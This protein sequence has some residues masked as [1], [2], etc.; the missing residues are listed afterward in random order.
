MTAAVFDARAI[1]IR[2]LQ[3][4]GESEFV[5]PKIDRERF[6]TAQIHCGIC[7]K[8]KDESCHMQCEE[9]RKALNDGVTVTYEFWYPSWP[10]LR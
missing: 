2:R 9:A 5:V 4:F 1:Q 6:G 3:I 8:D 10:L 7:P